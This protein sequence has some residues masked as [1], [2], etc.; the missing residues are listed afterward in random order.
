M[1]GRFTGLK[2]VITAT[3]EELKTIGVPVTEYMYEGAEVII[4]DIDS[5]S[6]DEY[7]YYHILDGDPVLKHLGNDWAFVVSE[8]H[9]KIIENE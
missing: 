1:K 9:F 5:D 7:E 6:P 8:N 4:G 3:K 2:A